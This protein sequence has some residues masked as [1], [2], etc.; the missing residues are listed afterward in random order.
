MKRLIKKHESTKLVSLDEVSTSNYFLVRKNH[1][2]GYIQ[3]DNFI[4]PITLP[5]EQSK[6]EYRVKAFD[7][8]TTANFLTFALPS[9]DLKL[10]LSRLLDDNVEI[11]VYDNTIDFLSSALKFLTGHDL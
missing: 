4:G 6:I 10:F 7:N 5:K 8:L 9:S 3:S 2:Y 1:Y 11:Y